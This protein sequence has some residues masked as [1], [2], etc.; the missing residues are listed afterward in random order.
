MDPKEKWVPLAC[1]ALQGQEAPQV[2]KERK[3]PL[4]SLEPLG[5]QGQQGL[6]DPRAHRDLQAPGAPQD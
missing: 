1:R 6:Q 3:V 2:P 4:V 5:V